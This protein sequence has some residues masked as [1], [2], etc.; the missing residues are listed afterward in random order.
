MARWISTPEDLNGDAHLREWHVMLT[1]A[2]TRH[3][4]GKCAR[5]GYYRVSPPLV[6]FDARSKIGRTED[7]YS[8][9]L[10]GYAGKEEGIW[11]L[12]WLVAM[13]KNKVSGAKD[14]TGEYLMR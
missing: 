1:H 8:F 3:Y 2:G 6:S 12:F 13:W 4:V 7:G 11:M 5:T 10:G 9:I 14:I